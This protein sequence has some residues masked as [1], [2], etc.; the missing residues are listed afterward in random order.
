MLW[1]RYV[2]GWR[3]AAWALALGVLAGAAAVYGMG[4]GTGNVAARCATSTATLEK[5]KLLAKGELAAVLV[6]DPPRALPA[7]SFLDGS[8]KKVE[9]SSMHGKTVLL[10]LWATWCVPCRTEMPTLNRLQATLGGDR[11]E[12]VA[13]SIDTRDPEKPRRFLQET[14]ADALAFYVDPTAGIFQSLRSVGRAVGMPTSLLVD[15]SGCSIAY[16]PGPAEWA[17]PDAIA[18]VEAAL[19]R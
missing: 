17:S 2:R 6:E 19:A 5:L 9:L 15:P 4:A 11:F 7:L 16:L 1:N 13:V 10:N 18:F 3:L 8:G 14:G 12:V